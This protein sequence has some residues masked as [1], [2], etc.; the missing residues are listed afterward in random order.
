MRP[1]SEEDVEAAAVRIELPAAE[2]R[3]MSEPVA[4]DSGPRNL[5]VARRDVEGN[6]AA[7]CPGCIAIQ[8][9]LPAR[10]RSTECR[11]LVQNRLMATDEGK[12]RVLKAQKRKGGGADPKVALADVPD[13]AEEMRAPDAVGQPEERVDP[14]GQPVPGSGTGRIDPVDRSTPPVSRAAE[15]ATGDESPTKKG[16]HATFKKA[17]VESPRGSKSGGGDLDD[18]YSASNSLTA[19]SF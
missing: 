6:Y 19:N 9:G 17:K 3:L 14:A 12:E 15:G 5:Y 10:A 7:G 16:R 13:E 1:K 4:R 8:V 18:L 2:G 11:T